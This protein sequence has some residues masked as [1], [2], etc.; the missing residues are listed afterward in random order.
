MGVE[1]LENKI[2]SLT[3]IESSKMKDSYM[4]ETQDKLSTLIENFLSDF[5][6]PKE[7]EEKEKQSIFLKSPINSQQFP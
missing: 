5:I 6:I 1:T 4:T 7:M 2:N 3:L